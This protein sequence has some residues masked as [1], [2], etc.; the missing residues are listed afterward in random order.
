MKIFFT[1]YL[2]VNVFSEDKFNSIN[3][4]NPFA[5]KLFDSLFYKLY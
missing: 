4:E 1:E 5:A 2:K 3:L